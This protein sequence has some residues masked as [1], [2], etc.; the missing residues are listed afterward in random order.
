MDKSRELNA[1]IGKRIR[2]IREAQGKTREQVAEQ[3]DIS[4]QFLFEI[5]TGKKGMTARTII[6]LSKTLNISADY[7]LFGSSSSMISSVLEGLPP[8]QRQLAEEFLRTFS[9][10]ARVKMGEYDRIPV[11]ARKT[12]S[13][14]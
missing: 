12:N 14:R 5:E 2:D 1:G 3:A 8:D 13:K 11:G 9:L 7:L 10:G 6:N 4:A